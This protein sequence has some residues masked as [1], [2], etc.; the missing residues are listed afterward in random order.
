[1]QTTDYILPPYQSAGDWTPSCGIALTP[2][3]R[4]YFPGAG[5][6]VYY[7]D[8]PDLA[9]ASGTGQIAF[10]GMS[11]SNGYLL[12]EA[13]YQANVQI[14]TPLT[15]D[16][17]GDIFF[18]FQVSGA[19]PTGLQSGIARIDSSGSGTWI[20]AAA[21]ANDPGIAKVV[22][23]CAPALSND[24]KTLYIAVSDGDE[25]GGYL[26]ALDS[27]TLARIAAARL[28][29]VANPTYDAL[30]FDD[31]TASP[32]V[33]P[34]G[35]VYFGVLENPFLSNHDRG[36]ML[37][38]NSGLTVSKTPGAFGWDDTPSIVPASAVPSYS[39]TSTYL[40]LTKY[41][42]YAGFAGGN[43]RNKVAVLDPNSTETDPIS[44]QTV[45]NEVM[46]VTGITPD[47]DNDGA[48]PGAVREWCINSSVIDP[49]GKCAI[50]NSE[51]GNVYRWDFTTNSLTQTVNL[52]A[53][54]GEAY[55]PSLVGPDGT[56]Y[57]I[58]NGTIYA[59]GP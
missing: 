58:N 51:D 23:N 20:A 22:M 54:I 30:L 34:D 39:G 12:N 15:S 36:W 56:V 5:G 6:T 52:N 2:A 9:T 26:V 47:P 21:A 44:R 49:A 41:N 33:G 31:G 14:N 13:A 7:R 11:G 38:F 46:T 19:T 59:I 40:L 42:N 16:R 48:D 50:V 17:Y 10:Y 8:S 1:M 25:S 29:D 35:D 53:G 32:T 57:V 55:T 27:R 3:N 45:M 28:K 18:G 24:H 43:G 4:L 37:H